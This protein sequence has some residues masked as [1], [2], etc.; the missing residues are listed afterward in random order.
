LAA[1]RL[2]ESSAK[3]SIPMPTIITR[4]VIRAAPRRSARNNGD[5]WIF[6]GGGGVRAQHTGFALRNSTPLA[7]VPASFDGL[8][9][10]L[11]IFSSAPPENVFRP[12]GRWSGAVLLDEMRS[13][14][15]ERRPLVERLR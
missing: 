6:I 15:E 7:R 4:V 11:E 1:E 14:V 9:P 12:T 8:V 2:I 3:E 13:R 10:Y 5:V